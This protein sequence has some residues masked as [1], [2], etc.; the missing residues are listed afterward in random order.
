MK[1]ELVVVLVLLVLWLL[2]SMYSTIVY[3]FYRPT[4]GFCVSSQAEWDSF[5]QK[6]MFS[7]VKCRDINM[8]TASASETA[9]AG[10]FGVSGVPVV[11]AVK[12]NGCRYKYEGDRTAAGYSA[13]VATL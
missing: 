9:L 10:N 2:V 6:C 7:M 5:K 8:D 4:C 12:P 1:E 11:F 13:W 3:R